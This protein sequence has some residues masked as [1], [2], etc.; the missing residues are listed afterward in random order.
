MPNMQFRP[1]ALFAA[2]A[3]FVPVALA[4]GGTAY[5][6]RRAASVNVSGNPYF[7]LVVGATWRYKQASGPLAGSIST[8]HVV[9]AHRTAA[10]E[11]VQV[12]DVMGTATVTDSYVIGAN[13]SIEVEVA[14]GGA[15]KVTVSGSLSRYFIPTAAQVGSCHPCHFTAVF[16]TSNPSAYAKTHMAETATS[17][18]VQ[19]VH[20]PAG[21]YR[22]EKLQMLL[23]ITTAGGLTSGTVPT[24]AKGLISS[25]ATVSYS[26]YLVKG[27]GMV[28]TGAGTTVASVMGHTFSTP[29]GSLELLN[30]TP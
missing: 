21:T 17:L 5:A 8:V 30:Y 19:T 20:V 16:T 15:S 25:S 22:A 18:G 7:P 28:E 14:V 27:V 4:G 2:A 6:S 9:S 29:V 11:A 12:Q 1:A 10:G 3:L 23:K 24:Y 26:L 13:G